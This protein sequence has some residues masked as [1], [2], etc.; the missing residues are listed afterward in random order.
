MR[1][2]SRDRLEQFGAARANE[3]RDADDLARANR[4]RHGLPASVRADERLDRKPYRRVRAPHALVRTG[5]L[6]TNHEPLD[7]RAVVVAAR[8]LAGLAPVAQHHHAVGDVHDLVEMVRDERDR[9]AR[10]AEF[11]DDS[12]QPSGL[13]ARQARRRFVE[14]QDARLS[15][16]R[17][18]DLDELALR[19]PKRPAQGRRIDVEPNARKPRRAV[20]P[21]L[22]AVEESE[23]RRLA[24]EIDRPRDIEILREVELL[25]HQRD[26]GLAR[27]A[28]A[29]KRNLAQGAGCIRDRKRPLARL[30]DAG[31]DLEK[32]RLPSAILAD[33]SKHLAATDVEADA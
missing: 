23:A 31:E 20:R 7:R 30:H 26:A 15:R 18:R 3:A 16:Q 1:G 32:R 12:E 14:N 25:M 29:V 5:D 2:D 8:K 21:H 19:D 11:V 10:R 4:E 22:R 6:A 33:D 17:L 27:S 28:H 9:D 13:P 24:A